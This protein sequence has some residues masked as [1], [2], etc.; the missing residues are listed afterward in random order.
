MK[1]K[2]LLLPISC[3]LSL[4]VAT[5]V[6]T[7]IMSPTLTFAQGNTSPAPPDPISTVDLGGQ[8]AWKA[9]P[10]YTAVVAAE[11]ASTAI[12]LANP[13]TKEP[14][15]SSY[16]SYDRMLA[17][18]QADLA[19]GVPI[20][21]IALKSFTKVVL[22]APGDPALVNMQMVDFVA[23]YDALLLQLHE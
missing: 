21:D 18:M 3:R 4:F 8:S 14:N 5:V 23:L 13:N 6:C 1:R 16:T 10:E 12:F 20:E 9:V 17:Y 11:R 22:E 19:A 7:M 15:T 2:S